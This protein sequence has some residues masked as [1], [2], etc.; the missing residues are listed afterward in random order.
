M[1]L[2][3]LNKNLRVETCTPIRFLF[4]PIAFPVDEN[5]KVSTLDLD[6]DFKPHYAALVFASDTQ[7]LQI[8]EFGAAIFSALRGYA[9]RY[10]KIE[11]LEFLFSREVSGELRMTIGKNRGLPSLEMISK[12]AE[13]IDKALALKYS[14]KIGY[15]THDYE[16]R[17]A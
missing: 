8:L 12:D 16:A 4:P 9:G 2:E 1:N 14:S 10:P 13:N 17:A 7:D 3:I 11:Q 6:K 15:Q 5:G